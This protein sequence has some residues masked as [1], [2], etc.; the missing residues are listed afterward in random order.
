MAAYRRRTRGFVLPVTVM[1][2]ALVAVGVALMAHQSDQLRTLVESSRLEQRSAAEVQAALAQA[3]TLTSV[4][5]RRTSRRGLIELDGRFYR[6]PSGTY[7]AWQDGAGL[8]NI[9]RS[10]EIELGGLLRALG[11]SEQRVGRLVDALLDYVDDDNLSRL[12][13]AEAAEY[14]AA[15]LPPP[16]NAPLLLPSE[17]DRVIGWR[18]LDPALRQRILDAVTAGSFS[19]INRYTVKAPVLAA[20][21]RVDLATA[22]AM[23]AERAAGQ[24]VPLE[25]L[26]AAPGGSYIFAMGRYVAMPGPTAVLT[27]CPPQVGWCQRVSLTQTDNGQTPWHVDYSVREPRHTPL[28]DAKQ[29]AEL[30]DQSPPAPPDVMTPF[31]TLQ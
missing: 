20:A 31:G 30:P 10:T 4:M 23:L 17:L 3:E 25:F 19:G 5:L 12:N 2:L 28:P 14:S 13:G 6:T 11:V 18:E 16:R 27:I 24:P 21:A 9:G 8:L 26:Q 1:V 29:V 22:Q 7:I 15:G